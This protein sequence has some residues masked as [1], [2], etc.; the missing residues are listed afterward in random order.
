MQI[1]KSEYLDKNGLDYLFYKEAGFVR[2][3]L[4]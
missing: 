2:D 1:I 3:L 4:K